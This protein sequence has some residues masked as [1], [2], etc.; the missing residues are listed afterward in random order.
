MAAI[1]H[2][3]HFRETPAPDGLCP[4]CF[5][6]ALKTYHLQRID[7]DGITTIGT[8]VACS[9]CRIWIEPVKELRE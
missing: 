8:R 7:L 4:K 9:D 2:Y 1:T 5:N 6:P 3:V